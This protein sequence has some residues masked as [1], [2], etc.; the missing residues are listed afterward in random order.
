MEGYAVVEDASSSLENNTNRAERE[1]PKKM[2][3]RRIPQL[4]MMLSPVHGG[5]TTAGAQFS[6]TLSRSEVRRNPP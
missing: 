3:K 2:N 1:P 4:H 6:P 5:L